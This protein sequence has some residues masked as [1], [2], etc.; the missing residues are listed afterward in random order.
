MEPTER[1]VDYVIFLAPLINSVAGIAIDLFAPSIPAIGREFGVSIATMQ[2]TIT[3]T[4]V[5]YAAGQL[6]FGLMTDWLGRRISIVFGLSL[7][8]LGSLLAARA[9]GIELLMCARGLQ[10]FAIGACQV[11]SRAVLVDNVK[12][13]RFRAA[14]AYLS[15]AFGLG[16]VISP[17]VGGL[18]DEA[19][20]WRWNFV[21]YFAYG[22]V[23]LLFVLFG[24]KESLPPAARKSPRQS[25]AGY[26]R[27]LSNR[28]FLAAVVLLGAS[29]SGFL[30][31]NVFGPYL[32]QV[33]LQQ[34]ASFFGMTAL[35]V[36]VGYLLGSLLNRTLVK[37]VSGARMIV[38][39]LGLF[40]LGIV[41]VA[42]GGGHLVFKTLLT[43]VVL[44]S[45]AQSLLFSNALARTMALFPEQAG[46]AASLQGCLMMLIGAGASG[47]VSTIT[48]DSNAV[49]TAIFSG[50]FVV[51]VTAAIALNRGAAGRS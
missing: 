44:I 22:L 7:F 12:G 41:L 20:G 17:Y 10:G 32:V 19:M 24:L 38:A 31:W 51:A 45:L 49:A 16:P 26:A 43:G 27:I 42:T 5:F 9:Q 23:V 21:L 50:I 25:L 13:E 11:V 3:V 8:L 35:A 33:R 40:A 46:T 15:V 29:L 47:V 30:M 36:G 48:V 39:G 2:N 37:W 1:Q 4:L 6:F 28:E 34:S 14:V 18:V